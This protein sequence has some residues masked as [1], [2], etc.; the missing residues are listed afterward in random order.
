[1]RLTTTLA[2][3]PH[4][5]HEAKLISNNHVNSCLNLKLNYYNIINFPVQTSLSNSTLY[6][7]NYI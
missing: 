5:T 1:M 7:S 2:L 6:E 4:N 3:D